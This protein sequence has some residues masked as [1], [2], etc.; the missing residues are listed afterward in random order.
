MRSSE[1]K[2]NKYTDF[3]PDDIEKYLEK[4]KKKGGRLDARVL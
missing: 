3:T 2:I 1:R 4:F